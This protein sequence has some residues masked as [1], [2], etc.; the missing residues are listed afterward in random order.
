MTKE[1]G[2]KALAV[3][4]TAM[5]FLSNANGEEATAAA[6]SADV[7]VLIDVSGS[8]KQ[9]D[10][11]NLRVPAL[12]L[13]VNLLPPDSQAGI[14]LFAEGAKELMPLGMATDSWKAKALPLAKKIHYRG[15]FTDIEKAITTATA[16]WKK[17]DD[18]ARRSLI[19][20]T[21]GMV[22]VSKVA[23]ESEA[24]RQRIISEQIL[25]MQQLGVQLHTVALSSNADLELLKKMA[26]ESGGWNESAE[27]AEQLQRVF[28]KMFKKAVPRDSVPLKGNKFTIDGSISEFSLLVFSRADAKPTKLITPQKAEINQSTSSEKIKWDHEEGYDLVTVSQPEAGEWQLI[29]DS[30]PDNQVMIVTDLKLAV[31]ELP[32]Y[33]TEGELFELDA[34]LTEKGVVIERADFI[35]LLTVELKQLDELERSRDW[36]L[37][38]DSAKKGHFIQSLGKTLSAGKQ[39]FRLKVDGKTFQREQTQTVVV[40]ENPVIAEV[41]A[42]ESG[43]NP[44]VVITIKPDEDVVDTTSLKVVASIANSAGETKELTVEPQDEVWSL[45]LLPPQ[46]NDRLI[47]NF[48]VTAKTLR[49]K[50]IMP[51][52]RPIIIDQKRLSKLFPTEPQQLPK[53]FPSEEAEEEVVVDEVSDDIAVEEEDVDDEEEMVE[54]E[55]V[56]EAGEGDWMITTGI[57]VGLNLILGVGGFFGYKKWKKRSADADSKLI[58]KLS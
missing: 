35:D 45:R 25:K 24:S 37:T 29:A 10:P 17:A 43:E 9:N 13:L 52:V 36:D 49:G 18:N 38:V 26:F 34:S 5:L 50:E 2:T 47:I 12:K 19:V 44:N 8:M 6:P 51:K 41:S 57:I 27:S 56:D 22:D 21:D 40:V 46:A 58:D 33:V 11:R 23:G 7:R 14:W 48:D 55:V 15:M 1:L 42:D 39:T 20:L 31:S 53:L 16:D 28:L 30:D 54:E 3:L 4:F 32:N